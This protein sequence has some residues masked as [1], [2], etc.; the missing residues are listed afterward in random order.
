MG[1][2]NATRD[3]RIA[4]IAKGQHGLVTHRQLMA[5]GFS[6]NGIAKRARTGRLHR[7]HRGVYA[8][9][10]VG[11]SIEQRWMAAVLALGEG[12]VLSH[13][14]AAALWGLLR[15]IDGPVDVSVP[16]QN[17][18]RRRRGIR[19]HRCAS[20][21]VGE[22]DGKAPYSPHGR[23]RRLAP[24]VTR[25]EGIPVT[26]VPR[27]LADLRGAVAPRLHRRATR[28]A[29]IAGFALGSQ[30]EGDRTRSDV[31]RDFLRLCRRHGLPTPEVN[32]QIGRWTVDFLWRARHL[33]VETDSFRYHR[34]SV[35][36][37]DDHQRD[38][39][40]RARGFEV[41]RFTERQLHE[42]PAQVAADLREA[43]C[44]AS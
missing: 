26:S 20:L 32:V 31:E 2:K 40:L 28:Q 38:L 33:A 35:A 21:T 43:L 12:A 11:S 29:E 36:F 8:V 27:T 24:S 39:D 1:D 3:E 17:G 4:E 5:L 16:T 19:I 13:A 7:L 42:R 14:S 22:G 30:V 6:S 44:A 37:E 34:G 41:R 15:P 25:R 10:C 23:D 9:G 18:R